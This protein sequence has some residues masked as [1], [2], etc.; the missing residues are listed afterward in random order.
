MSE[1][2]VIAAQIT[3]FDDDVES[4]NNIV[5]NPEILVG[6]PTIKGTRISVQVVL[7]WLA[8]GSS[9][10]QI[11]ESYPH[12][13][14]ELL[15]E[16]VRYAASKMGS[17]HPRVVAFTAKRGLENIVGKWPGDESDKQMAEA[18]QAIR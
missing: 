4:F 13:N 3:R 14:E 8:S 7:E 2:G 18:L 10:A 5:C 11:I 16:A 12:L 15:K 6:K 17:A 1:N 9:F